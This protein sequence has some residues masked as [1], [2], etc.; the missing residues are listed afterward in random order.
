MHVIILNG[1]VHPISKDVIS[2][3]Y[4]ESNEGGGGSSQYPVVEMCNVI[5]DDCYVYGSHSDH[6]E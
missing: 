4:F 6:V 3:N 1:H 2:I 5:R